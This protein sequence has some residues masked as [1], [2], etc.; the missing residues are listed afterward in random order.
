MILYT[1]HSLSRN[2]ATLQDLNCIATE[3]C[4]G[5]A[6]LYMQSPCCR[7]QRLGCRDSATAQTPFCDCASTSGLAVSLIAKRLPDSRSVFLSLVIDAT[8]AGTTNL[9][10]SPEDVRQC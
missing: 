9:V 4:A 3:R 7:S 6:E 8:Q 2:C 1:L 5:R 10:P